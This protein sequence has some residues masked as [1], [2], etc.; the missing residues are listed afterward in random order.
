VEDRAFRRLSAHDVVTYGVSAG[1]AENKQ[2]EKSIG[3]DSF[4][5]GSYHFVI[6]PPREKKRQIEELGGVFES[7][8]APVVQVRIFR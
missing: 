6:A 1:A 7:Q 3:Q 4:L 5:A 8:Q 2:Q